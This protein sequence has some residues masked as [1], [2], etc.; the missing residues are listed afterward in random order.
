MVSKTNTTK[1]YLKLLFIGRT[2]AGKTTLI[3]MITNLFERKTYFDKRL[4][5][6]TQTFTQN[7]QNDPNNQS[8][9]KLECTFNEFENKQSDGNK[10]VSESQTEW[11]NIYTFENSQ[12]KLSLIDT[13][14]LGDTR[15][16]EQDKKNIKEIVIGISKVS[17][18]NAICLVQKQ[19]DAR[20][21]DLLKYLIA[22]LRGMLTKECE[23]NFIICFTGVINSE[24]I[25]AIHALN[26]MQIPTKNQVYFENDCLIPSSDKKKKENCR[27]LLARKSRKLWR[28]N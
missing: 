23:N 22:E 2:G 27:S 1:P 3:N 25:D 20:K 21:D 15:G 8:F 24:K 7:N 9:L 12:L 18:F 4:I 26:E 5:S 19:N 6:I 10:K 28:V 17:D 14:G 13:P 16:P 11:C